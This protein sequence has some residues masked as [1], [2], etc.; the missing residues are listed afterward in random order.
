MSGAAAGILKFWGADELDGPMHTNDDIWI[1]QA[2]GGSNNGWPTFHGL[3]T[4][5]GRIMDFSTG[6]PANLYV[7]MEDVFLGGYAE[8]VS[9]IEFNPSADLIRQNGLALGNFDTDIV[10]VKLGEGSF[11]SMFGEIVQTGIDTVKVY[12]WFPHNAVLANL[13]VDMG[14]NW[15]EDSDHIY[16]NTI[17][18]YDTIWTCG[19]SFPVVNQ[20]V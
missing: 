15:Y 18:H 9:H 12:S 6:A 16:T 4:T 1:Q 14:L 19:P 20:S 8:E 5:A 10:Y 13:V 3:V 11:E 7:P 2:G 17:V